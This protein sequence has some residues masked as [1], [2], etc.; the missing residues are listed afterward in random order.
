MDD[1]KQN[2]KQNDHESSAKTAHLLGE[3]LAT[4]FGGVAGN[5]KYNKFSNTRIGKTAE[6]QAGKLLEL[7]PS[8]K[9]G[10]NALNN[11]GILDKANKGMDAVGGNISNSTVENEEEN[12]DINYDELPEDLTDEELEALNEEQENTSNQNDNGGISG[13]I[14]SFSNKD[15]NKKNILWNKIPLKYKIIIIA[16]G[17]ILVFILAYIGF[18]KLGIIG[19]ESTEYE[20]L[21]TVSG[22]CQ[23]IYLI[24]ET[25][26]YMGPT[27]TN[28]D[29]IDFEEMYDSNGDGKAD[30]KRWESPK[31]Y[32]LD[33]Y[34]S[35]VLQAEA[36]AVGDAKTYEVAAIVAR[37]YALQNASTKCY[38]WDNTNRNASYRNPQQFTTDSPS[39]E[40][41][42]GVN[43]SSGVTMFINNNLY[44][45]SNDGYYDNFCYTKKIGNSKNEEYNYYKMIQDNMT[46]NYPIY[47]DWVEKNVPGGNATIELFNN[48]GKLDGTCQ[49]NGLSLFGAKHLLNLEAE[50]RFEVIDVLKHYYGYDIEL[51]KV[52]TMR[53]GGMCDGFNLHGTTL[54]REEFINSVNS[55]NGGAKYANLAA[56]AGEIYDMS[57]ANGFNPELVI[58]R[59]IREGFSG[60]NNN[61]WG[62]GASN[63][64][65]GY[66]Y[67]SLSEGVLAYINTMEKYS[68]ANT[69]YDT[70]NDYHYAYIG[71][72]WFSPGSSGLGGCYYL[73]SIEQYYTNTARLAEVKASCASGSQIPTNDEDQS[74]YSQWQVSKMSDE[75]AKIFGISSD[76]NFGDIN[77]ILNSD[78][79]IGQ[80]AAQLAVMMFDSF[81]YSKNNRWGSNQVDCSSLVYRTYEQLGINFGGSSTS[82]EELRWCRA[83]NR[84]ISATQLQPGDLLF[85][86]H[87]VEIY[88]GNGQRFGAHDDS[89]PWDDQVSIKNFQNN[90]YFTEFCR[91]Y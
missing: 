63:G 67:G 17:I 82:S 51:K 53:F 42:T 88:I 61:Y 18:E 62:I 54:T 8:T 21:A 58:T 83:N 39:S 15:K 43:K 64:T 78:A 20:K 56:I 91:P 12:P 77:A 71:A 45:M 32:P 41:A 30:K 3:G 33:T 27:V 86:N 38:L 90:G 57:V 6:K 40:I 29:D 73:P 7:N 34:I 1:N 48:S 79:S 13:L 89:T 49:K 26:D 24:K 35:G 25:P 44:D 47:G 37:T 60:G 70:F 74:A 87:H 28:I 4:K 80:K 68:N 55:Y 84:M 14:D 36:S 2:Q 76:C 10:M 11:S 72:K 52:L 16:I 59:A 85:N 65:S 81:G 66:S 5:N 46:H 22:Y 69:L 31:E 23:N 19:S 75:R 9:R 50:D